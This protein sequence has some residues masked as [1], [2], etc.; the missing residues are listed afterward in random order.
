MGCT[1]TLFRVLPSSPRA[2]TCAATVVALLAALLPASYAAADPGSSSTS[3]RRARASTAEARVLPAQVKAGEPAS[4]LVE[5]E[6]AVAGREVRLEQQQ[7]DGGWVEVGSGLSDG[8]GRVLLD[9]DTTEPGLSG[10]AVATRRLRAVVLPTE[11]T[12]AA[13]SASRALEIH[14]ETNCRPR[15]AP[16][17]PEATGEAICLAARLDS[18]RYARITGVGQQVNASSQDWA[19]PLDALDSTVTVVGFDLEELD[20]SFGYE[21][22]FG[23][24]VLDDLLAR[25]RDGAVLVAS[26]H[27]TNPGTGGP[28]TDRSWR[29]V[30]AL[31]DDSTPEAEAFWRDFEAKMA[32]LARFQDGD[33][34]RFPRT[35]VV[36]RPLHEANG[37]FFWWGK[38]KR[39]AYRALWARMQ[40]RAGLAGVHNVLWAYSFN[41][42][43]VG[44]RNPTRLV[45]ARIDLAGLDSYDPETPPRRASEKLA[46][47]IRADRLGLAGYEDVARLD[48]VPRMA[49]TEVGPHG[50]DGSWN[51]RVITRTVNRSLSSRRLRPVWAMLW[52]DDEGYAEAGTKQISSLRGG[53]RWLASCPAGFCF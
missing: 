40:A 21:H 33:G 15:V 35:A 9:V 36:L 2:R 18:W 23:Q 10:Q 47:R 45:P 30:K 39:A 6:P 53:H 43:T 4:V 8:K 44:V 19:A 24:Q 5:L 32:L 49:L 20:R 13:T 12:A 31:L 48:R 27:A 50:S 38:P 7:D 34:G 22:P 16:V 3:E 28:F 52:F 11:D 25:A 51:P 26:W 46:R 29:D 1:A 37:G 17:D 41:L 42:H 14:P